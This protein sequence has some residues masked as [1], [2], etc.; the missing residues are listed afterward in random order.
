MPV[1]EVFDNVYKELGKDYGINR[2]NRIIRLAAAIMIAYVFLNDK[3]DFG[4]VVFQNKLSLWNVVFREFLKNSIYLIVTINIL[5]DQILSNL[6]RI[7]CLNTQEKLFPMVHTINDLVEY[8]CSMFYLFYAFN[9]YIEFK[10]T[11]NDNELLISAIAITYLCKMFINCLYAKNKKRWEKSRRKYTN[12]F[13]VNNDRIP[14]DAEVIYFGKL[15][16]VC[17][18]NNVIGIKTESTKDEW[19]LCT[20]KVEESV[21]LE[22]AAKNRAGNLTIYKNKRSLGL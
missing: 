20:H 13:D 17:C 22:E 1:V 3:L 16:E 18:G 14:C 9:S 11:V 6:L 5:Y 12:Y 2:I 7:V 15:Y 10:N 8:I 19:R 21:S 4:I